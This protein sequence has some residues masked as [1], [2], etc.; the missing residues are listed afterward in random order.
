LT[1]LTQP[2]SAKGS[3]QYH[4]G[5]HTLPHTADPLASSGCV[6]VVNTHACL[7]GESLPY[8]EPKSGRVPTEQYKW[9][10]IQQVTLLCV[11][12]LSVAQQLCGWLRETAGSQKCVQSTTCRGCLAADSCARITQQRVFLAS[13]FGRVSLMAWHSLSLNCWSRH[14]QDPG[15]IH[16]H[17]AEAQWL[18]ST[19]VPAIKHSIPDGLCR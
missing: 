16:R 8:P 4:H 17:P 5:M 3:P 14:L 1:V 19:R 2:L 6:S 9:L 11:T 15:A 13:V 12:E 7:A 10:T 18:C